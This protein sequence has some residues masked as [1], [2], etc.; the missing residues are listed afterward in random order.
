M[1]QVTS[2]IQQRIIAAAEQLHAEN[3][4]RLP[5]VAE[6]R[7]V[8][9]ADMN[10]VS[11]V[12]KQ[13]RQHKLMP[14]QRIEEEA[15]AEIQ[16]EA[17][18]LVSKIWSVAKE[19]AETKLKEAEARYS[20]ERIESEQLRTELS[21]VCDNLQQQ[22]DK[23]LDELRLALDAKEQADKINVI[24]QSKIV[25]LE[26]TLSKAE[27]SERLATAKNAELDKHISTLKTDLD[28]TKEQLNN[29]INNE[30][31]AKNTYLNDVENLKKAHLNDTQRLEASITE[32]NN[33]LTE[34]KNETFEFQKQL[35]EMQ[36]KI[37]TA[38]AT[39]KQ[40]KEHIQDLKVILEQQQVHNENLQQQINKL[41]KLPATKKTSGTKVET[42][43]P[44]TKSEPG[45]K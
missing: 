23:T 17:K 24:A 3:P 14:V 10:S 44:T 33:K 15:P 13:W 11:A 6:V 45:K 39:T 12:M 4:D 1:V 19:Q 41:E 22:L 35:V 25:E 28:E 16:S 40:A 27:E 37:N 42:T 29:A 38:E 20:E 30:L 34:L 18:I 21:E 5:T 43:K 26:K 9:K 36:G 7:T 31:L 32:K 8:S 2:D